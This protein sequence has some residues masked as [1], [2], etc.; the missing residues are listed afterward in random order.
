MLLWECWL[1]VKM[2]VALVEDDDEVRE[3]LSSLIDEAEACCCAGAYATGEIAL[4]EI[5]R[6]PPDVILVD[7]GLPGVSGIEV[8]RRLKGLLPRLRILV[9]TVYEDGNLIFNALKAGADGYLLKRTDPDEIVHAIQEVY[10]G[11][12]PMTG[13][14]ARKVIEHFQNHTGRATDD[15]A[16]LSNREHEVLDHLA[17][18]FLYKEIADQLGIGFE[19]VRTHVRHI[20]EKLHVSTRTEAVAKY[21]RP[22]W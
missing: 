12:G 16:A 9:L 5:P 22:E 17:R 4:S 8:I 11:G 20:Y 21:L 19:T 7:I 2:N 6:Q 10:R 13:I 18:G 14:V 15:L 3:V 1:N